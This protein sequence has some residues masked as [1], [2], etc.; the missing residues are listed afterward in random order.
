MNKNDCLIDIE[1]LLANPYQPRK[2][3]DQAVVLEIAQNILHNATEE[4]DGLLQ[5]P[6][7]REVGQGCE[8][9]FGH[10]RLAAFRLLVEQGHGRYKQMRVNVRDLTDLQMFELAVTEN[11]KRRDL[12][13]I[14]Q[15]EAIHTYQETFGKTSAEAA[16]FFGVAAST[17]RGLVRLLNLP[18]AAREKVRS[19]EINT[20]A[21][22][23]LLVVHKLRGEEGV[24]DVFERMTD[25]GDGPMESVRGALLY[26]DETTRLDHEDEWM[27]ADPF[28]R[29]YWKPVTKK[30][31][32]D[33]LIVEDV[34]ELDGK[35]EDLAR[36]VSYV[37][38][39][40]DVTDDV[41][42][43]FSPDGLER[44][45]VIANPP[46]CLTCPLHAQLDG[47]HFCGLK[48]CADRKKEAWFS[49]SAERV[50][51][52]TGIQVYE[53]GRDGAFEKLNMYNGDSAKMFRDGH[54][55]LRLMPA[56]N[57][58]YGNH[59]VKL[60]A[61]VQAVLVGASYE[62]RKKKD[63]KKKVKETQKQEAQMPWEVQSKIGNVTREFV[64]TVEW[65]ASKSF[66]VLFDG[67]NNFALLNILRHDVYYPGNLNEDALVEKA[68]KLKKADGLAQM[69][70]IVAMGVVER[71]TNYS[72]E[73][74]NPIVEFGKTVTGLAK[75]LGVK[76]PK[77][78]DA[79][80]KKYQEE[81]TAAVGEIVKAWKEK[82]K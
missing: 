10:T 70:R 78:W 33:L 50:S 3:E 4:F 75:E 49:S 8:L 42:S 60:D 44:V 55:D 20:Q 40:M 39:G 54:E 51:E 21:A 32:A 15:A 28:P 41:F 25:D 22:R 34:S 46:G 45:R 71:E 37:A 79:Q 80:V 77:D 1:L 26:A 29:K 6:T 48:A 82:G 27:N 61:H 72:R 63:E 38:G 76:L 59:A 36:L 19:G 18:E 13:P 62:K 64:Y 9:A 11:I 31:I 66:A 47:D 56:K 57:E 12:N 24:A 52:E 69:R 81:C 35:E 14:E 58:V 2:E 74:K 53:K 68:K 43:M 30:D 7:V 67:L 17:V 73:N 16:E 5:V 65:E 23:A